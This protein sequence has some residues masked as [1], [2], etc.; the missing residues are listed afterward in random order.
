M[1]PAGKANE[2]QDAFRQR[3]WWRV[4][5][6]AMQGTHRDGLADGGPGD[7]Q[8]DHCEEEGKPWREQHR[9]QAGQNGEDGDQDRDCAVIGGED[10][11]AQLMLN[12]GGLGIHEQIRHAQRE[13][14]QDEGEHEAPNAVDQQSEGK[15]GRDGG[16]H[17]QQHLAVVGH[18]V[19]AAAQ[20]HGEDIGNHA[21]AAGYAEFK[22][23]DS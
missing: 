7:D 9:D 12:D 11:A 19:D 2:K 14:E 17:D 1:A 18:A 16:Q 5:I 20:R 22:I 3:V 4:L 8:R 13:A 23:A 15:C 10:L 6:G 21:N